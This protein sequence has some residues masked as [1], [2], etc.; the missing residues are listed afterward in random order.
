MLLYYRRVYLNFVAK[1]KVEYLSQKER[2]LAS[3]WNDFK[4]KFLSTGKL[5][6]RASCWVHC[7]HMG[8]ISRWDYEGK[9]KYRNLQTLV[10]SFSDQITRHWLLFTAAEEFYK[11][12]D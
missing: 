5:K 7:I 12:D 2:K 9:I 1:S 11:N 6:M 8:Q 10:E 4:T 3:K